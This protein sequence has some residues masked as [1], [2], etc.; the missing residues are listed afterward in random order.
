MG[1]AAGLRQKGTLQMGSQQPATASTV[2]LPGL[3]QHGQGLA[4]RCDAAGHQG[5][6]DRFDPIAPQQL[7]QFL[8]PGQIRRTQFRESQ[9]QP[10][11]DLQVNTPGAEPVAVPVLIRLLSLCAHRVDAADQPLVVEVDAVALVSVPRKGNRQ[12]NVGDPV[13]QR[14]TGRGSHGGRRWQSCPSALCRQ[15]SPEL[16]L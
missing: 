13:H 2:L 10:A 8:K 15:C 3:P 14:N 5:W 7:E 11:V 1:T 12:T 4:Q 6:C 9:P 16:P